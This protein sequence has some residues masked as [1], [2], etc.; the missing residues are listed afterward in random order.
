MHD[1]TEEE[2]VPTACARGQ[3]GSELGECR[4]GDGEERT[5][6]GTTEK[7]VGVRE[8]VDTDR[9]GTCERR[10]AGERE[11]GQAGERERRT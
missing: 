10:A 4:P 11:L 6:G 7:R 2:P 3:A 9:L 1:M 8:Q 5:V